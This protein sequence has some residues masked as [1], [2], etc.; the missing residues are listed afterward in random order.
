M[1]L[2]RE[3]QADAV[4]PAVDVPTL[5]RKCKILATRLKHE[6]FKS[7][8]DNELN[9]YQKKDELPAYRVLDVQSFGH[10]SGPFGSGLKNAPIPPSC[11][12]KELRD[13]V[14]KAYVY[15]G[16]GALSTLVG[17]KRGGSLSSAWPAD[18]VA[19]YGQDIY[20]D[21]NCIGAWRIIGHSQMAGI[22]DTMRNRVLTF[23]LE[24]EST[25]P[26]AG[27]YDADPNAISADRVSQLYQ[28][29]ILGNVGNVSSGGSGTI[30]SA[31]VQVLQNDLTSL[32]RFLSQQGIADDDITDL[33]QALK[34]DPPASTPQT[35]GKKVSDWMGKMVAKAANGVWKVSTTVAADVLSKA[36]L[37]YYGIK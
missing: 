10:F 33:D 36:L 22:L 37:G 18:A 12:P 25:Y 21:M 16:V 31:T 9:G 3:I 5:L 20:E 2:L 23:V 15:E 32:H 27:E 34:S 35:F 8:V 29:F 11:L 17:N 13:L 24:I 14:T 30:Q 6:A 26:D 4:N 7:W 1:T 19:R 28:T